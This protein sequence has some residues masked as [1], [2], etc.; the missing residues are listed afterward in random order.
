[1]S[2]EVPEKTPRNCG[3]DDDDVQVYLAVFVMLLE[4]MDAKGCVE[5]KSLGYSPSLPSKLVARQIVEQV[6]GVKPASSR[7]L[8]KGDILLGTAKAG[9]EYKF[10]DSPLQYAKVLFY[11]ASYMGYWGTEWNSQQ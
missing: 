2:D 5:T 3:D 8:L 1:M 9:Y 4:T 7:T 6:L 10:D 11:R